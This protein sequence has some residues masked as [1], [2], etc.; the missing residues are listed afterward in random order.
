[1]S[2]VRKAGIVLGVLG[3]LSGCSSP[4]KGSGFN[5]G[6]VKGKELCCTCETEEEAVEIA[7]LYGIELVSWNNKVAVFH[8]EEDPRDVIRYGQEHDLP[9]LELNRPRKLY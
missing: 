6:I 8:T 4:N 2:F 1:M 7:E 3:L 5:G 9:L